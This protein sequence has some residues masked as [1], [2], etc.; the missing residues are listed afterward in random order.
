MYME[1]KMSHIDITAAARRAL[2]AAAVLL[3]GMA[4]A[5][6]VMA[7]GSVHRLSEDGARLGILFT[8]GKIDDLR[9]TVALDGDVPYSTHVWAYIGGSYYRQRT[10]E[11]F[12]ID[13]HGGI[14]GL[15]DNRFPVENDT[16]VFKVIDE[17]IGVDN[18]GVTILIGYRTNGVLK[19]GLFGLLPGGSGH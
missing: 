9:F 19:Y 7:D 8:D 18:M 16:V 1:F 10:N 11:G 3:G 17:D 13:L 6:P 15:I 4:L 12:W 14:E 5:M 2:F